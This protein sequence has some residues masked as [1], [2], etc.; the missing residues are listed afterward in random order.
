MLLYLSNLQQV[1]IMFATHCHWCINLF[2][3]VTRKVTWVCSF[4][5]LLNN[6]DIKQDQINTR[7]CKK[8][9]PVPR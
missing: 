5:T 3:L 4:S 1:T 7:E 2:G 6:M 9:D 8:C